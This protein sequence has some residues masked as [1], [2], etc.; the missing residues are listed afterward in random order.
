MT[1]GRRGAAVLGSPISHSLSPLLHRAAYQA[2]G[3]S[4]WTY[5]AVEATEESLKSTLESLAAAGLA[6]VSLT[7]PL[8]KAVV[9]LLASLDPAAQTVGAA[10]TVLFDDPGW[11]GANT[12]VAGFVAALRLA[13][14]PTDRE[15]PW[16][17]GAGATAGSALAALGDLGYRSVVVVARRPDAAGGLRPLATRV[18]LELSVQPWSALKESVAASLVISTAPAGATDELAVTLGD[19]VR[20]RRLGTWFDV[21]YAPWPTPAAAAWRAA[22]GL[23]VG[24]IELLIEQAAEQVRLMTGAEPPVDAMRAAGHRAVGADR[25]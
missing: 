20:G 8:K 16:V 17:L 19:L 13:R 2:L 14:V 25:Y 23:V 4:G 11:R 22:G 21:V 5:E 9:P 15:P 24:G 1:T 6:G 18:G 7:M 10:N 3:L 12:D